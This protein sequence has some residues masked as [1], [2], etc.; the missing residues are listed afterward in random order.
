DARGFDALFMIVKALLGRES[1]HA[2]IITGLAVSLRVAQ[3]DD[4]DAMMVRVLVPARQASGPWSRYGRQGSPLSG[5][6]IG[7]GDVFGSALIER[8]EQ[9]FV[10]AMGL[11]AK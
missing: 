8:V 2:D 10:G 1:G 5:R 6:A 3:V 7:R 11:C 4:V 9:H